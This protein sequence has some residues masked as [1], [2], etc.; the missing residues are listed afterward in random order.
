[1]VVLDANVILRY[2]LNDNEAM[3][4]EAENVIKTEVTMVPIEVIAEVV[5]V[6]K[7]V[8]S[9]NTACTIKLPALLMMFFGMLFRWTLPK[10][11]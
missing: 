9:L 3:A 1:M 11:P 4:K 2:L 8:F 6:L 5:Y 7:S 10:N